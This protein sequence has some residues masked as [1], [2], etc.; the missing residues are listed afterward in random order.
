MITTKEMLKL[1][2]EML[3]VANVANMSQ[4]MPEA[5]YKLVMLNAIRDFITTHSWHP[6]DTAPRDE[7]VLIGKKI[8]DDF[9][10]HKA[11]QF[12]ETANELEGETF[13]G[14]VWSHDYGC[15][16]EPTH[17]M[18]LPQPPEDQI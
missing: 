13:S 12:Y 16:D 10:F 3:S 18:P 8:N 1:M 11:I 7:W 17:W 15:I 2:D 5:V 6:I 9:E 4:A 14:W